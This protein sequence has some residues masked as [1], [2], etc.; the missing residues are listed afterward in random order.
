MRNV[1][2]AVP[3]LLAGH[4]LGYPVGDPLRMPGAFVVH[5]GRVV[6]GRAATFA[7]EPYPDIV[8]ECRTLSPSS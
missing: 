2:R 3:A 7:G 1:L 8:G 5:R 4:G 6:A